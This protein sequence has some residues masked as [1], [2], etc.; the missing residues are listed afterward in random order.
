MSENKP[1]RCCEHLSSKTMHYR[2]DERPG[3]LHQSDVLTYTCLHTMSPV[4][5]DKQSASPAECQP[6]RP[7]FEENL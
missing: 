6:D 7:C 2:P 1:I 5:P 3:R 4:G